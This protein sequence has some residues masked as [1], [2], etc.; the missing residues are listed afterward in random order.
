MLEYPWP[1]MEIPA[2]AGRIHVAK[3]CTGETSLHPSV[4]KI[5]GEFWS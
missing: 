4:V 1:A 5:S 3:N 2:L